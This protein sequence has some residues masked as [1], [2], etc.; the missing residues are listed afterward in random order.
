MFALKHDTFPTP[1]VSLYAAYPGMT[2]IGVFL[3]FHMPSVL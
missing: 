3:I 1:G 2:L